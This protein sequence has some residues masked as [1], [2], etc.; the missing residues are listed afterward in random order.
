MKVLSRWKYLRFLLIVVIVCLLG[1]MVTGCIG[2]LQSVGW[3]GIV[4]D[5]DTL[6]TG[7]R[8]GMLVSVNLD[9]GSRLKA[10]PVKVPSS[11]GLLGC[12]SMY[13]GGGCGTGSSGVAIYGTPAVTGDMAYL[14]SYSGKIYGYNRENLAVRWVYPREDYVAPFVGSPVVSQGTLFIGDSD[15]K[16]YAIDALTG[17]EIWTYSTGDKIWGT[18]SVVDEVVYCGSFD[19]K[20]YALNAA[21]GTLKWAE[22]FLTDG[23][24]I[25]E[26]LIEDGVIYIG[27]FDKKMYA[28]DASDG[29]KLW[30][31]EAV[32]WFWAKPVLKGGKLYAPNLD[33]KVYVLNSNNGSLIQEY[34]LEQGISANPVVTEDSVYFANRDG[35]FYSIDFN[36]GELRRIADLDMAVNGPLTIHNDIVYIQGDSYKVLRIDTRNGAEMQSIL[37]AG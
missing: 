17:D 4:I 23:A 18:A 12:G 35:V 19:K 31:Y 13:S 3:S 8:E 28:I 10:E 34:D 32:N 15:G 27:S 25:A 21:D 11:G 37:L 26:P 16:F 9:D 20:L 22:A 36:T 14:V 1:V 2:G 7:S 6:F 24:I 29:S 33:S 5:D 30:E